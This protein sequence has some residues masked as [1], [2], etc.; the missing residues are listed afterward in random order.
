LTERKVRF[1][2]VIDAS[3]MLKVVYDFM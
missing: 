1:D 2:Q 3:D